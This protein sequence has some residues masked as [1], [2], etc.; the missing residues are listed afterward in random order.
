MCFYLHLRKIVVTTQHQHLELKISNGIGPLVI[1]GT[2]QVLFSFF[3]TKRRK[4][5]IGKL[6]GFSQCPMSGQKFNQMNE[7][8]LDLLVGDPG[9][10]LKERHLA[11]QVLGSR[12]SP[13]KKSGVS[14]RA[15]YNLRAISYFLYYYN[16]INIL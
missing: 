12:I 14:P 2:K 13:A 3:H 4:L 8:V 10:S 16:V 6:T 11:T 1:Y 7:N 15:P 5:I 9:L